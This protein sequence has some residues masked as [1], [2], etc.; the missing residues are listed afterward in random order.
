M[1]NF[2]NLNFKF[3]SI[4]ESISII[5]THDRNLRLIEEYFNTKI[6]TRGESILSFK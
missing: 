2:I 5:G 1:S 6:I 4:E 3:N